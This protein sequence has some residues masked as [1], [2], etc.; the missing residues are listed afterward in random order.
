MA[1]VFDLFLQQVPIV[2]ESARE[3]SRNWQEGPAAIVA[4]LRAL[5]ACR[6]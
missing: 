1:Q 4:A 6:R 3:K 5:A 2:I